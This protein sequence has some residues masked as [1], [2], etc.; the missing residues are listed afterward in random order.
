M[1]RFFEDKSLSVSSWHRSNKV[2]I[3]PGNCLASILILIKEKG[4][5]PNTLHYK[6]NLLAMQLFA[7]LFW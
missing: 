2:W 5:N 7:S 6:V 3:I 1:V 4:E